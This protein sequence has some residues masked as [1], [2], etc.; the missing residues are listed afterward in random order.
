MFN[1]IHT[2]TKLPPDYIKNLKF[3]NENSRK[4]GNNGLLLKSVMQEAVPSVVNRD[5]NYNQVDSRFRGE[6]T[7]NPGKT[8]PFGTATTP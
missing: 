1:Y 6:L 8:L 5:F 4:W 7:S 3:L 2:V